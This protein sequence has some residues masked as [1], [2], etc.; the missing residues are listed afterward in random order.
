MFGMVTRR[1]VCQPPAPE[2][3]CGFFFVGSLL[4]R[5]RDQLAGDEGKGHE[6]GRQDDSRHREDDF[7]V[8]RRKPGANQPMGPNSRT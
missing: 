1:N 2:H 3:E 6:H 8:V 7:D 4:L 5:Q